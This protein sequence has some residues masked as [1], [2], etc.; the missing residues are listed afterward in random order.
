MI[1]FESMM[2]VLR[3]GLQRVGY[4][5]AIEAARADGQVTT[6]LAFHR[7]LLSV[8][9]ELGR[10]IAICKRT[11]GEENAAKVMKVLRIAQ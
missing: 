4:L 1:A 11:A 5:H 6:T 10:S 9:E 8:E 7:D 3:L 2:N